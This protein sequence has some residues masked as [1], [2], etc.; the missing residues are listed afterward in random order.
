MLRTLIALKPRDVP[1]SVALRN[2]FAVVLP[3]AIG[4][5][6]GQT[7]AGLA[8][9]IG[10]INTMGADR[11]GPYRARLSRMMAVA[12]AAA[13]AAF[14]GVLLSGFP[15]VLVPAALVFGLTGGLLVALGP[16]AARV[17]LIGMILLVVSSGI[18]IE[19]RLA[20]AVAG[21]ILAGGTLQ[22][23]LALAAWPLQ[24]YRPERLAL[25]ALLRQ[26][27]AIARDRPSA[28]QAPPATQHV[29]DAIVTLHG[30]HRSR[31]IALQS[32]RIIAALSERARL[33]LLALGD[34]HHRLGDS[35]AREP[36]AAL[37]GTA[38]N[39]L[40]T[41]AQAMYDAADPIAANELIERYRAQVGELETRA[42]AQTPDLRRLLH[43]AAHR[44]EALGGQLRAITRNS[45]WASSRG[46]IQAER[47]EAKLPNALRPLST[48][49][50]LRANLSLSSVAF[51]HALRCAIGLAAGV[52]VER[53]VS[54]P[55]SYW[56]PMTLVIVLKPDFGGTFS[57]GVLRMTGTIAG[58]L[59][60]T[61]LAHVTND[62][63][64]IQLGLLALFCFSFRL[65]TPVNY[66]IGVTML[67][68]MLVML[69]SFQGV[70]PLDA[71][72]AR[73]QAT[74]AGSTMA[75]LAYALW[76][77]RERRHIRATL[78]TMLDAYR[79][80]LDALL[81]WNHGLLAETRAR[82]RIARTNAQASIARLRAEPRNRRN[83]QELRLTEEFLAN[84]NRLVRA[85]LWL[86][87]ALS[88]NHTP[89][90]L[91]LL[92]SFREQADHALRQ[93]ASALEQHT[94][95]PAFALR[96]LE[97][98]LAEVLQAP[99]S[100]ISTELAV[101]LADACDRITD[102]IGTLDHLMREDAGTPSRSPSAEP[103]A[104]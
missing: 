29:L 67:T 31:G 47:S 69:L 93:L 100:G 43:L 41:L 48:A 34:V 72:S 50:T 5:A 78:A 52:T 27:A 91:P 20:P 26:L 70:P 55:H 19:P 101:A 90:Q 8:A 97:R 51:R 2:T 39:L 38:S 86:E 42:A 80:H 6:L 59:I 32:F 40:D 64:I 81:S 15:A 58:L 10:A 82:C 89:P 14:T 74:I 77:T 1:V 63:P 28:S 44:A 85:T 36:L 4:M 92:D 21:L 84:A 62:G 24:R 73:I 22:T 54:L 7:T 68:G 37:L 12:L 49:E 99:D 60:A 53:L 46:E 30:E 71:V 16:E 87:A 102:S 33:E 96:P 57:F 18:G 17:G 9:S 95:P 25:A 103:D 11:P 75:L 94:R 104:G 79:A 98:K 56:I 65:L 35:E 76:P 61:A 13:F 23:M 66:A 45:H 3:L 83:Q 88:D